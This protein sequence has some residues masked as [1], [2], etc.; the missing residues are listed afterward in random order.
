MDSK[1]KVVDGYKFDIIDF[2]ND[3]QVEIFIND[4][5]VGIVYYGDN[6]SAEIDNLINEHVSCM[7]GH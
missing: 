2:P 7:K 5:L 3:G 6:A 4:D 1:S